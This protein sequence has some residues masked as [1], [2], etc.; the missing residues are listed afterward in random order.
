MYI[1]VHCCVSSDTS[2]DVEGLKAAASSS[3]KIEE[4]DDEKREPV[5]V[6]VPD[7][8]EELENFFAVKSIEQIKDRVEMHEDDFNNLFIEA[9]M[10]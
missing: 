1:A 7:M 9:E 10:M 6:E 8:G 2:V 3:K 4:D 5:T